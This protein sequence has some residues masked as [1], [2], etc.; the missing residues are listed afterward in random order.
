MAKLEHR[1]LPGEDG[2]DFGLLCPMFAQSDRAVKNAP[3]G[4]TGR[5]SIVS[6]VSTKSAAAGSHAKAAARANLPPRTEITR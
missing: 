6:G 3:T 1:A 4:D 5:Y 2:Q